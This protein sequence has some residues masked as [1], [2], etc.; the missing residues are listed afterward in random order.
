MLKN[1]ALRNK[2]VLAIGSALVVLVLVMTYVVSF[3][4]EK[5]LEAEALNRLKAQVRNAGQGVQDS[6]TRSLVRLHIL[7]SA[8]LKD[9]SDSAFDKAILSEYVHYTR[10]VFALSIAMRMIIKTP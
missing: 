2:M 8:L 5:L 3:K 4:V 1:M 7:R 10:G 6:I 9:S